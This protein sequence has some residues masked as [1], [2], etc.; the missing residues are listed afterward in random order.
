MPSSEIRIE[1]HDGRGGY[2]VAAV[3]PRRR[4]ILTQG[5]AGCLRPP[6]RWLMIR[7]RAFRAHPVRGA[8]G[9]AARE[10][11]SVRA[12]V[13]GD[14]AAR[15]DGGRLAHARMGRPLARGEPRRGRY[16]PASRGRCCPHLRPP[17]GGD[18]MK[19][20]ALSGRVAPKRGEPTSA[21]GA[22]FR[23]RKRTMLGTAFA[24]IAMINLALT[25]GAQVVSPPVGI[26]IP[27]QVWGYGF[28]P[29]IVR[30]DA[31]L[32]ATWSDRAFG[33][34]LPWATTLDNG[35]SWMPGS[36]LTPDPPVQFVG[37]GAATLVRGG[38]GRAYLAYRI[39]GRYDLVHRIVVQRGMQVSGSWTWD[40][41]V[42]AA[43]VGV[44]RGTNADSPWLAC[45]PERSYLYL[46]YVAHTIPSTLL[47]NGP[48]NQP[49]YFLR[50]LDGGQTWS[51]PS[52]IGGPAALGSRVE[53]GAAG[54]VYVFWQDHLTKQVMLRRSEDFGG[55]FSEAQPVARF[56]DN[57]RIRMRGIGISAGFEG[58]GHPLNYWEDGNRFDFPQLAVD[59]SS[60]P[61][62][63]TLYMV[64]AEAAEGTLG[65]YSGRLVQETEPNDTPTT[66]NPIE[67]GDSFV[68]YGESEHTLPPPNQDYFEFQGIQGRLV[69]LTTW[70]YEYPTNPSPFQA[71]GSWIHLLDEAT[72]LAPMLFTCIGLKDGTAPPML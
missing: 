71:T 68:S 27:D 56:V 60:G 7:S 4:R 66:G 21:S 28:Q 40:Q 1:A 19:P 8:D 35:S 26:G 65:P 47:I 64:W 39:L 67:I 16:L 11:T 9:A 53:V 24:A 62:R 15:P 69:A 50:S 32:V 12:D 30:A 18:A 46:V 23:F 29:R 52:L 13:G 37:G 20:T 70:L 42:A 57:S 49:V 3:R 55:T 48:A 2:S 51:V 72:G 25:A 54:E 58:R 59:L 10:A 45:D 38:V 44:S 6:G 17:A 31:H 43:E 34:V 5:R 14:A 33:S 36:N 41:P 63:G 61:N 22:G